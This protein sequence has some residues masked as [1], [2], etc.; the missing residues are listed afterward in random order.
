MKN[1]LKLL[2]IM[3]VFGAC[4][5]TVTKKFA[6]IQ[7]QG[8]SALKLAKLRRQITN[9]VF[10]STGVH[11]GYIKPQINAVLDSLESRY[12]SE[13]RSEFASEVTSAATTE[14]LTFTGLQKKLIFSFWFENKVKEELGQ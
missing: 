14:G 11:A 13:W 7:A 8:I 5:M 1:K 10:D 12:N 9:A 6:T 3:V 4:A 2:L